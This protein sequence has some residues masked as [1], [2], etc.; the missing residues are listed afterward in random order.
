MTEKKTKR[1]LQ[2]AWEIV[3][4]NLRLVYYFVRRYSG[5][6]VDNN[7]LYDAGLDA[8]LRAAIKFDETIGVKFTTYASP[9]IARSMVALIRKNATMPLPFS[10]DEPFGE[11][12][13]SAFGDFIDDPDANVDDKF[14]EGIKLKT[15]RYVL[16]SLSYREKFIIEENFFHEKSCRVIAE[17]LGVNESSIEKIRKRAM[18]KLIHGIRGF[19]LEGVREADYDIENDSSSS[20]LS[21]DN[22]T[23]QQQDARKEERKRILATAFNIKNTKGDIAPSSVVSE[24]I[25]IMDVSLWQVEP[26][27]IREKLQSSN[28]RNLNRHFSESESLEAERKIILLACVE[29]GVGTER[30]EELFKQLELDYARFS[31]WEEV[32]LA[33][34]IDKALSLQEYMDLRG[35]VLKKVPSLAYSLPEKQF[36]RQN[37]N[38]G[39]EKD[40]ITIEWKGKDKNVRRVSKV[41]NQDTTSENLLIVDQIKERADWF[42]SVSLTKRD[43][44]FNSVLGPD[45]KF[46]TVAS[47]QAFENESGSRAKVEFE[48]AVGFSS[49]CEPV[50]RLTRNETIEELICLDQREKP[51]G[52]GLFII[53][54]DLNQKPFDYM[55]AKLISAGFPPLNDEFKFDR[56]HK[57]RALTR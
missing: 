30:A 26:S 51:I 3:S 29:Y 7:L 27:S 25:R 37:R 50:F 17:E 20:S 49:K 21:V 56:V 5:K 34:A 39:T 23:K 15:T 54:L 33:W 36:V 57:N 19:K 12:G 42:H 10:L 44:I 35:E 40:T 22:L 32:L 53:M 18:D 14:N 46:P 45:T 11:E 8:I 31:D 9:A 13:D 38:T 24:F 1:S 4:E 43:I 47:E 55:N 28:T 16:N 6:G 2:E 48:K 52:R 41:G